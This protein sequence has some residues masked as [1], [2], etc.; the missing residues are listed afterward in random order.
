MIGAALGS[1]RGIVLR[2][3]ESTLY[4]DSLLLAAIFVVMQVAVVGAGVAFETGPLQSQLQNIDPELLRHHLAQSLWYLHGQP[5]LWNAIVGLSLKIAHTSW[6][7]LWHLAYLLLGLVQSQ[8]FLRVANL[9]GVGRRTSFVLAAF[10]TIAPATIAFEHWFTYD[11]PTFVLVTLSPLAAARFVA[12]PTFARGLVVFGITTALV[13]MRTL[14]QVWW[15]VAVLGIMLLACRQHRRTLLAAAALPLLVVLALCVKQYAMY[16]VLGTTSWTGEGFARSVVATMPLAERQKLVSEGKLHSVSLVKPY[17]PL[18]DYFAV[19]VVPAAPTGIPL[20]DELSGPEFPINMENKTVIAISRTY[21]QDD[22]WIV[23]HRPGVYLVAIKRALR[24]F[25]WSPTSGW[26]G[27]GNVAT[28]GSYNR[29]VDEGVYGQLGVGRIEW[30]L[31]AF[32]LVALATSGWALVRERSRMSP[33]TLVAIAI[34]VAALLQVMVV[35]NLTEVGENYRF[36]FLI[37]P[38]VFALAIAGS[39]LLV[40]RLRES[41][42]ARHGAIDA[43]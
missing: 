43:S 14:F 16:G 18:A 1:A 25:F 12:Q 10:M 5:P 23:R 35:G 22:L 42:A 37:D 28:L 41:H 15:L 36:R 30:F 2:F 39:R 24:D 27:S 31:I 7:T 19:G 3:K 4:V 21:W 6:P 29:T 32:Y 9:V 17:S 38:L 40:G 20:L 34:S 13:L 8:A 33:T 26:E 11:Y